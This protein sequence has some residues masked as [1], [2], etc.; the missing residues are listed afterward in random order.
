MSNMTATLSNSS[1]WNIQI[2][3]KFFT[4][5]AQKYTNNVFLDSTLKFVKNIVFWLKLLIWNMTIDFA[6][7][8]NEIS[9]KKPNVAFVIPNLKFLIPF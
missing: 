3:N 4:I 2:W 1:F 6:N 9:L 5:T 7:W 8:N